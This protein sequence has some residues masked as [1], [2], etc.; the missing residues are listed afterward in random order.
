[1]VEHLNGKELLA[2]PSSL[3]LHGVDKGEHCWVVEASGSGAA[4][5]PDCGELSSARHSSYWR[6]LKDLPLQ[7]RAVQM[8][9]RVG[10][11]RCRNAGCERKIFC[12]RLASVTH[13]HAVETNRFGE[14]VQLVAYAL[15]GR[16][17]ER[18]STRLGL[19]VSDDTL[20]RRIKRVAQSRP[21]LGPIAVVGVDD[22][23]WR[24]GYSG[25][26]TIL[27]D[28]KQ[29]VVAD[30]LPDRS[31]ASFEKWLQEHPGVTI[32]SRDRHGVYAEGGRSGAPAAKQVADR[33]HLVQN[34]IK[35]VQEELAQQRHHLLMPAGELVGNA[36]AVEAAVAAAELT[37]SQPRGPLPSPRQKEV[38]Q[39]RRQQ[40]E[41]LFRMVKGLHAQGMR[42]FEIVKA[43]EI[44]R[45][46]VDK[47]LRLKECPPQ[48]KMAP[49]PGMAEYFRE[50]LRRLW[51]RGCQ[52]GKKLL[53]EIRKL[54]YIGSYSGLTTLLSPW[55]EEKR[56]AERADVAASQ[57]AEQ[58]RPAVSAMRNVSPQE[59]ASLL[60]KPKPMLSERQSKIVQFLKRTPDF[61]MMRHLVLSFRSILCGGKVSS[62]N[63]WIEE[64]EA[65]GIEAMS[66]FVRQLK[67]D[68]A[69]VENAVE[70]AWSNGPVEGHI[71]R[72]KTLKRQMYGR[73]EFE[74][75]RARVLP[76]P[77]S[78]L[79]QT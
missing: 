15:G 6:H 17:G 47:W 43:T 12:Q 41:E 1:M 20:L 71:N 79:H 16:P 21:P 2:D 11:W 58:N 13:K 64:A 26:G 27:V 67:K 50:E 34:L 78:Q 56:A 45:G 69:A 9:L 53:V 57:P 62:M 51:E 32:I 22:W 75:L 31:A 29:R 10:R 25:Y 33:F 46:R 23:A 19:P 24:K 66:R 76:F 73:A 74:L 49:R 68:R 14:V 48:N 37:P 36:D 54:G 5:C 30:L 70:Q 40:K 52:N 77:V 39:Q 7:G 65:V 55:R 28:L 44:S 4:A 35:A 3:L 60:S 61:A 63:R 8:K 18:L 72:L 42:A 38:R 59:A